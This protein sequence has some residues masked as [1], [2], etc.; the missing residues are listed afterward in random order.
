M[1]LWVQ[2]GIKNY[3]E[4]IATKLG[5]SSGNLMIEIVSNWIWNHGFKCDHPENFRKPIKGTMFLRCR[6]CGMTGMKRKEVLVS[7]VQHVWKWE[8]PLVGIVE[9]GSREAEG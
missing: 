5:V 6:I 1:V 9:R 7:G 4:E 8:Y 3:V 2:R